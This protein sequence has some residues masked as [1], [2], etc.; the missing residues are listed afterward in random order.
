MKNNKNFGFT[1]VE[2]LIAITILAIVAVLGWRGLDSIVRARIAL[3]AELEQTRGMQ[4]TFAQLQSDCAHIAN[5]SMVA[6]RTTLVAN[7]NHLTMLRTVFADNQPSRLQAVAYRLQGGMLTRYESPAT[8][9]L[10]ELEAFWKTAINDTGTSQ[11][12]I[13]Q[14]DVS[15]MTIRVWMSDRSGWRKAEANPVAPLPAVVNPANAVTTPLAPTG[16]EI[17]LQLRNQ[18][19]SMVK[20]F[21]LGAT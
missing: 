10:K 3:T 15:T 8:R 13:L 7:Q 1:L 14:P 5:P 16:L 21:L 12:V 17:A 11:A 4:I 18:A 19:S 20:L 2:L 6:G 9:N